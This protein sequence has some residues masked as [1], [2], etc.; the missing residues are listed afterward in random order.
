MSDEPRDYPTIERLER[1]VRFAP[2]GQ[3]RA[4]QKALLNERTATLVREI[5]EQGQEIEQCER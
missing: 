3:K 5:Q 2:P 1:R 4:F